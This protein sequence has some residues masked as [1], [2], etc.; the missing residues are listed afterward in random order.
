MSNL[1][2]FGDEWSGFNLKAYLP[3]SLYLGG[4][5]SIIVLFYKVFRKYLG[6]VNKEM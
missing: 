5:F 2:A 6:L 1:K 3:F 4:E